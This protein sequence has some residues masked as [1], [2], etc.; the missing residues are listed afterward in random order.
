M[1][2]AVFLVMRPSRC[3]LGVLA[4][5]LAPL[6][7]AVHA[8]AA[9]EAVPRPTAL[10]CTGTAAVQASFDA[11]RPLRLADY[12]RPADGTDPRPTGR[13][14]LSMSATQRTINPACR[15]EAPP[16]PRRSQ[17]LLGPYPRS[18]AGRFYC[19]VQPANGF[20]M[21][22]A[23]IR[24]KKRAVIGTR[25]VVIDGWRRNVVLE[26]RITRATASIWFN[27]YHNTCVRH[28]GNC[29]FTPSGTGC[30]ARAGRT[31]RRQLSMRRRSASSARPASVKRQYE[32]AR[33]T[34]PSSSPTLSTSTRPRSRRFAR[35]LR[36]LSGG[37]FRCAA[38]CS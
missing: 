8:A 36:T 7:T 5:T 26:A 15:R 37:S 24:N 27:G 35:A 30:A 29:P 17:V 23:P 2:G 21:Q 9:P 18:D 33:V 25:L 19:N 38:I 34:L 13:V 4:A 32:A 12:T 11:A 6:S 28:A 10:K 20:F 3:V 14:W 16:K 31:V 1:S 22:F